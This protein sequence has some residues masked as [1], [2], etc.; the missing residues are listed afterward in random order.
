MDRCIDQEIKRFTPNQSL[1]I[2]KTLKVD[3][4]TLSNSRKHFELDVNF[5]PGPSLSFECKE[6]K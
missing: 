2:R 3:A 5:P 6:V 1:T 4:L